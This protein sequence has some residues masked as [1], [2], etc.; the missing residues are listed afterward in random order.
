MSIDERALVEQAIQHD[1]RAFA[2]L[3]D[4]YVD[5]IYKYIYYKTGASASVDDLT[6]QVFL[7]AW[8]S[9]GNYRWTEHPFA[10]WL[11]RIAHNL[12]I[13][14]YRTRRETVPLEDL[15]LEDNITPPLD[16]LAQ[17]H[18]TSAMLRQAIAQLTEDQQQVIVL[19]FIDGYEIDQVAKLLG[20][21][22]RA[23]RSLQH[24]ALGALQRILSKSKAQP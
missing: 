5:K 16:E 21:D 4:R 14:Y 2:Q 11:F 7:K 3:Y 23:V 1:S 19:K 17:S 8:E 18:L 15:A 9:I 12:V 22:S 13:D 24:R 20:K 10:A 6:A